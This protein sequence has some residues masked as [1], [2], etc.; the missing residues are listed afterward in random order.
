MLQA[1]VGAS[2]LALARARRAHLA[3]VL[4]TTTTM[5]ISDVAFAAGFTSIRQFNDTVVEV[6]G[7]DP[8]AV[9]GRQ[10]PHHL[11]GPIPTGALRLRLQLRAPFA[12]SHWLAFVAARAVPEVEWAGERS[13]ARSLRLPGGLGLVRLDLP[14][15]GCAKPVVEATIRLQNLS[16]LGPAIDRCRRLL[17]AD[18]DPARTDQ[19]LAEDPALVESIAGLPGLRVPGAVDGPEIVIRALVGQQIS[20]AAAR[21]GLGRLAALVGS[22]LPTD[23]VDPDLPVRRTFPTPDGLAG[24]AP[25]HVAGPASR[26]ATLLATACAMA[27]GDLTVDSGRRAA[28]LTADL[29]ARPGIGPWTAGYVAMRVIGDPDVL[30]MSDLVLRQGAVALGLPD[31]PLDLARRAERWRPF[32]SYAGMHLWQAAADR[33]RLKGHPHA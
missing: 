13:Y 7:L 23:L 22:E 11:G 30:L 24:L 25:Q 32:R 2:P 10:P 19:L 28:E 9:R 31:R 5:K 20:V 6:L 17:D 26:A 33:I 27:S 8:T 4:L 16:D 3:R 14:S 18:A 12:A 15:D 29:V 1:E 21:T